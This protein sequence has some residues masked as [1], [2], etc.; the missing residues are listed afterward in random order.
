MP[1]KRLGKLSVLG[2]CLKGI[3]WP[4]KDMR[5]KASITDQLFS[6]LNQLLEECGMIIHH[7][8]II[9]A[10]FVDALTPGNRQRITAT[11]PKLD[12]CIEH[13]LVFMT[14]LCAV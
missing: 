7:G 11:S 10:M 14:E 1:E 5:I 13:V 8:M 12:C 2:D 6:Q 3:D 9:D 4:F